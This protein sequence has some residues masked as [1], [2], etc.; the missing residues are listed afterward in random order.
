MVRK[1]V[2]TLPTSSTLNKLFYSMVEAILFPI[3]TPAK[4]KDE[5][6]IYNIKTICNWEKFSQFIEEQLKQ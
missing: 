4:D 2:Q 6:S 3:S 1:I 5:G